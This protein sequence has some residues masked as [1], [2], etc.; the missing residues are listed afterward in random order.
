MLIKCYCQRKLAVP[1]DQGRPFTF[2]FS[3][4][5]NYPKRLTAKIFTGIGVLFSS[6]FHHIM[7][8]ASQAVKNG[9]NLGHLYMSRK[10]I[11][12][13][14]QKLLFSCNNICPLIS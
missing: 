10:D 2:I 7:I 11:S 9:R 6:R 5:K 13:K 8:L 1:K 12:Y 4:Y 14:F 3:Q